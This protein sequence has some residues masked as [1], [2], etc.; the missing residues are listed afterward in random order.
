MYQKTK[1]NIYLE[2]IA[3]YNID[4]YFSMLVDFYFPENKDA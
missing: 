1:D 4:S 2:R 3:S